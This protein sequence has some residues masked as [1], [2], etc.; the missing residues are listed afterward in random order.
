MGEREK[1]KSVRVRVCANAFVRTD[2]PITLWFPSPFF[3]SN[4]IGYLADENV[5]TAVA[6]MHGMKSQ[7]VKREMLTSPVWTLFMAVPYGGLHALI[8][9]LLMNQLPV[10]MHAL[11]TICIVV[12]LGYTVYRWVHGLPIADDE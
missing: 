10:E 1:K 7:V 3:M 12:S 2:V 11:I 9:R 6:Y 5:I 8:A 4:L